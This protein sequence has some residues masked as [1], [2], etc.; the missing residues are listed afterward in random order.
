MSRRSGLLL[1]TVGLALLLLVLCFWPLAQGAR[2]QSTPVAGTVLQNSNLRGGPGTNYPIVGKAPAGTQVNVVDANADRTWYHLDSNAWIAAF[3]VQL[4][5]PADSL[6]V[7]SVAEG[8]PAG[9]FTTVVTTVVTTTVGVTDVQPAVTVITATDAA[10]ATLLPAV[11]AAVV[12]APDAALV[13]APGVLTPAA[14]L[15]ATV[16][17]STQLPTNAQTA[18]LVSVL[19]GD[20]IEVDINGVRETVRYLGVNA[21]DAGQAGFATATAA[22]RRLLGG[23]PLLLLAEQTDRDSANRL[24]RHVY[25]EDKSVSNFFNG[26]YAGLYING[27]IVADGWALPAPTAPDLSKAPE[28]SRWALDAARAGRGFWTVANAP[29]DAAT[30]ALTRADAVL[31]SGPGADTPADAFAALDTPLHVLGRSQDGGWVQ[32]VAPRGDTGWV[33]VPQVSLGGPVSALA[34]T[35]GGSVSGPTPAPLLS[36]S[37]FAPGQPTP[38]PGQVIQPTPFPGQVIQPTP[39]PGQV[40]QPTPFPGQVIQPTPFPGQVIQ[41]TPFPGQVVQPTP[42]PGQVVQPTPF[43]GQV[44]QPTP[45]PGQV[46]PPTGL[47]VL[48]GPTVIITANLRSGPGTFFPLVGT[49]LPGAPITVTARSDDAAWLQTANNAWIP[50]GFVLGITAATVPPAVA[51]AA[52]TPTTTPQPTPLLIVPPGVTAPTPTITPTPSPTPTPLGNPTLTP[53]PIPPTP[54]VRLIALDRGSEWVI[55]Y[56]DGTGTQDLAGWVLVSETGD[57]RCP[58]RGT[59]APRES[60]RVWAQVGPDGLSCGFPEP[61][62]ENAGPDAAI[63]LDAYG[64]EVSRI[65]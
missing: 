54:L 33:Y 6:E 34:D 56:N 42:F 63:L 29:G 13:T 27:Q 47:P 3:L 62:W 15:S 36:Q 38:F 57:Q 4:A 11:P 65:Q 8:Q 19:T 1:R 61:I 37:Q 41:P 51:V 20:T 59:L 18:T 46:V 14:P 53:T 50:S 30:F 52:P 45:L 10:T 58:L 9:I 21:P 55:L 44:I 7:W 12:T 24:L 48:A 28:L 17:V 35:G 40:I 31:F 5:A 26:G 49:A 43:P 32:T 60:L 23:L 22:N 25:V 39:F 2:A 16:V 64:D